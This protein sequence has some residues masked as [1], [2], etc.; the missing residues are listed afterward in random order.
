MLKARLLGASAPSATLYVDDVFSADIYTGTGSSRSVNNGINLLGRE[1]L[2]WIKSRSASTSHFL[3]D[4]LRGV[5]DEINSNTTDAETSLANSLTA[6]NSNGFTVGGASGIGVNAATYVAWSFRKARK[7]F[8]VLT[9]TGTGSN[10]TVAHNLGDVP[11]CI[12]IKRTDTSAD[13]QVYHRGLANTQ[14]L[15]LNS[16]SAKA[17]GTNRWNSTTPTATEFSLGNDSTVNANGGTY[18]AYLF[19]HNAGGFGVSGT[20]NVVACGSYSSTTND[21]LNVNVGFEPQFVMVKGVDLSRSWAMA[22]TTRGIDQA[23]V[24]TNYKRLYADSLNNE[25]DINWLALTP[26]GFNVGVQ[27][28]RDTASEGTYIY[29]A[30]RKSTP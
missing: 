2:V 21:S 25:S 27:N 4:T 9:Y 11:G 8:D 7:F 19:A 3:F 13:W 24:G 14:Y 23:G 20:D 5:T 26:T 28:N 15:V 18:V 17:T 16:S 29:I 12:I 10:R 1:G 30:I 6:F 22:D